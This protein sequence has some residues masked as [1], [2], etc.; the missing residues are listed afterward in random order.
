[1]KLNLLSQLCQI[2]VYDFCSN[3]GRLRTNIDKDA[4]KNN[5]LEITNTTAAECSE[6]FT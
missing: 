5:S 1:M 4:T 3:F 6:I 2:T